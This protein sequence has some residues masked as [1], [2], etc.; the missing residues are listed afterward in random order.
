MD[1][2]RTAAMPPH[3]EQYIYIE[4]MYSSAWICTVKCDG[5][6]TT[7]TL[8]ADEAGDKGKMQ[9]EARPRPPTSLNNLP[10]IRWQR[11][12]DTDTS[13]FLTHEHSLQTATTPSPSIKAQHR[14]CRPPAR[15]QAKNSYYRLFT[16]PKRTTTSL[17]PTCIF[18]TLQ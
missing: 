8:A 7:S 5:A 9:G 6:S 10:A 17:E 13:S 18:S 15:R 12:M 14:S 4:T 3:H 2:Q 1:A 16:A 11:H